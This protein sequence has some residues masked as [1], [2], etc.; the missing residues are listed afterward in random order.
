MTVW[1]SNQSYFTVLKDELNLVATMQSD[2]S[3][4]DTYGPQLESM[5]QNQSSLISDLRECFQTYES[6]QA[7]E[8]GDQLQ[9][10]RTAL[11]AI[12]DIIKVRLDLLAA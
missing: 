11:T 1:I 5:L 7:T 12:L 10:H 6:I 3:G 4:L 9:T 2:P 8:L